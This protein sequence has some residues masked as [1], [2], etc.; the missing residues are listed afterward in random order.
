MEYT[1]SSY[2]SIINKL[3]AYGYTPI[4]FCDVSDKIDNPVIIRH[5]VD[6]DLQK[7]VELAVYEKEEMISSTY[8]VLITSDYYN[9]FSRNNIKNV[10]NL[11]K[12]GHE[13]GLHF[14]VTVYEDN[15][16][17]DCLVE[18][19]I[20]E[21]R[22]LEDIIEKGVKSISWHIPRQDLIGVHIDK[23][24][25]K[26]IYNAYDPMFYYGYK[27]VSDSMMRWREPIEEYV[28][29]KRYNKMQ[30]LTHPIWYRES[31]NMTKYEIIRENH[32]KRI[33]LESKYL[34]CICPGY[35]QKSKRITP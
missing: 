26:G 35:C 11:M 23:L 14:D 33:M 13:I 9:I 10:K 32:Q 19:V 22:L 20:K 7:A 1:Y 2:V 29:K 30:I 5:D 25:E 34:D 8:F 3:R 15:M 4:R 12:L 17:I 18:K 6:L 31:M 16:A 24:D 21:I 28:E 27:Y